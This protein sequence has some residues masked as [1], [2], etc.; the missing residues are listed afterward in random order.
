MH[1]VGRTVGSY[2][3][4]LCSSIDVVAQQRHHGLIVAIYPR[5]GIVVQRAAELLVEMIE[6]QHPHTSDTKGIV[7][8]I[9]GT[10]GGQ[11]LLHRAPVD[12]ASSIYHDVALRR[13]VVV[14]R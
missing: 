6:F 2:M 14:C 12:T 11:F 13:A 9:G 3:S 10:L 4:D 1:E 7:L 8:G 5:S